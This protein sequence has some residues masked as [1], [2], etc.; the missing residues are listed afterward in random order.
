VVRA[1]APAAATIVYAV[2][3]RHRVPAVP[4]EVTTELLLR[5]PAL[6]FEFYRA[7]GPGGQ[8][9][10]KVSTAVRLR[11]DTHRSR[12]LTPDARAR[13]ERVPGSR[14]TSRGV[15]VIEAQRFRT[16]EQNRQDAVRRL[17]AI[18]HQALREPKTRRPTKPTP[19]AAG[20]RLEAKRRR[21]AIKARRGQ[22]G[23][24]D[25]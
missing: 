25:V 5:D 16:Q 17:A 6:G 9:V 11:Y 24:D 10:N 8:N 3:V 1:G 18:L 15:L 21:S 2:V 7:A 19:G 23:G 13:L 20:R 12:L 4:P 14:L 22:V